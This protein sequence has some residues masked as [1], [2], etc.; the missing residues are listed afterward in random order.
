MVKSPLWKKELKKNWKSK[1]ILKEQEDKTK[2]W[3]RNLYTENKIAV[4]VRANDRVSNQCEV[5]LKG[6]RETIT[7]LS[8]YIA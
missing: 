8:R 7:H 2:T 4:V 3:F 6:E 5:G 1:E